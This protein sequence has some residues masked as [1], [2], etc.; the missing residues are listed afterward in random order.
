MP[1]TGHIKPTDKAIKTYYAALQSY[2]EQ[3]VTHEGALE[4]AFQRL[5]N[6]TA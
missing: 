1:V 4:T 3:Q 2:S 5:L 6:D